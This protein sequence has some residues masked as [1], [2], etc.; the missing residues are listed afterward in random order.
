MR[1]A[2][3]FSVPFHFWIVPT[4][5][6]I[7]GMNADG[8]SE[9]HSGT[10]SSEQLGDSKP[11]GMQRR[12]PWTTAGMMGHPDPNTEE[13]LIL[14][15][16]RD[17]ET[18]VKVGE[19]IF[20]GK[21]TC[22]SCHNLGSSGAHS[23]GPSL[24]NIGENAATRK[25]NMTSKAYLIESLYDPAAFILPGYAQTM[26][27][28]WKPP[29]SLSHL[30]IEAVVA[31]LQN[32]GATADLTPFTPPI[33]IQTIA[34]EIGGRPLILESNAE[35]GRDVFINVAKCVACHDVTG[36]EKPGNQTAEQ[37]GEVVS[38]PD[39]T[40]IAAFNSIQYIEESTLKPNAQI[41]QG[42]GVATVKMDGNVVQGT[43]V[44]QNDKKLVLRTRTDDMEEIEQTVFLDKLDMEP[45][46]TLS[47]L[48]EMGYFWIQVT[49][50][51]STVAIK[52]SLIEEDETSIKL[53][54]LNGPQTVLKSNISVKAILTTYETERVIGELISETE[55]EVLLAVGGIERT[56]N[57]LEDIDE[58]IVYSHGFGKRL[59]IHSPMPTNYSQLLTVTQ[60]YD[61]LAFLSTLT[62]KGTEEQSGPALSVQTKKTFAKV[63]VGQ[64]VYIE[65]EPGTDNLLVIDLA[66]RLFRIEDNRGTDNAQL[67]LNT[68]RQTYGLAFHPNYVNKG[69]LYVFS[70]GPKGGT[71]F[72]TRNYV[73][74]FVVNRQPPYN[75]H[76]TSEQIIMDWASHEHNGGALEFGPDGYL[77]VSAGDGS[78]D[79]DTNLTGEPG[80][81][82]REPKGQDLSNILAT[83]MRIDVDRPDP[84]NGMLYSIPED[85]PFVNIAGARPEIWVYGIRNPWRMSFDRETGNLWV[86]NVG[87]D[88]WEMIHLA[89][90]GENYG[91]SLYEGSHPF[92]LDRKP[93]PTPIVKP[94]F[95]HSHAESRSITGGLVYYGSRFPELRGAYIYGDYVTGKIWGLKHDGQ[96]I[97]WQKELGDTD[98]QIVSFGVD[99]A[100]ELLILD[101]RL[102]LFEL[103]RAPQ[104]RLTAKFPTRLSDTGLFASVKDHRVAPALIPYSINVPGWS[105][106][107]HV[108][109]YIALPA[110]AQIEFRETGS[111]GFPNQTVLVQTLGLNL[112]AGNPDSRRRVETRILTRQ[113][114]EWAGYSYFWNDDETD[115][116]LVPA[117]GI[118]RGITIQDS[119]AP[120]GERQETW[121][122]PSRKE[123]MVCHTRASAFVLGLN[124]L[125][126]NKTHDYGAIS[127]AQLRTLDHIKV[128]SK[129]LSK[130]PETYPKLVNPYNS[131]ETLDAR[132]RSYLHA[133][134]ANCHVHTGGGNALIDVE[135]TT[136]NDKT[137]MFEA[138]PLHDTFGIPDA[139]VVAPGD[140]ERST[141]Y[142][143]ISQLGEGHMPP[144][145][146]SRIDRQ[147]VQLIYDWITQMASVPVK[148]KE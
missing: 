140:P 101:L 95:E 41:T 124:T 91:W 50:T 106:G 70:N 18:F 86:G 84:R 134:C 107:A 128:F 131:Q 69:W 49:P 110:D 148:E 30:E 115:A 21:G 97:I 73:S 76:E 120:D 28:A 16:Q 24:N 17:P 143:R 78:M 80:A 58:E 42:Y 44:S 47:N 31:F 36:I 51:D 25:P 34:K 77:Y 132:A 103:Q 8:F 61:L 53:Q 56:F 74:R 59:R 123:C 141:L 112:E 75:S 121:R 57:K 2:K 3:Y 105:D 13:N 130:S 126:M 40:D 79:S 98:N 46:E 144:V 63:Q 119:Q 135:F 48:A 125:Q 104:R 20:N 66:G 54:T 117:S 136:A 7:L 114:D 10:S 1:G 102:G 88:Q 32:Q 145:G 109:R 29:I 83:I 68:G 64:P 94:T 38:G 127:D 11:F 116:T 6:L 4:I 33:D 67:I 12:V 37:E 99:H 138:R 142:Y 22:H 71:P 111:W 43:L 82:H 137:K 139:M 85:N 52:G 90:R 147:G 5:F 93:G 113:E 45:I 96:R 100:G 87:Q 72:E 108:E 118:D 133:N 55:D 39:L 19:T 15:I 9:Q 23:R 122:Y 27:P 146:A 65:P 81:V 35:A 60:F 89:R 14:S 92:Y 26:T 62:G 129:P